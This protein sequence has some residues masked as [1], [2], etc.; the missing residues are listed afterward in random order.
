VSALGSRR[1]VVGQVSLCRVRVNL[2]AHLLFT[3]EA[4]NVGVFVDTTV[5]L[6]R[7]G[8]V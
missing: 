6:R 8:G 3:V 4:F 7:G 5:A 1:D 2:N